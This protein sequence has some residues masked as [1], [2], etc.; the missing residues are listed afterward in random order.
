MH[1]NT[2]KHIW[3]TVVEPPSRM[4]RRQHANLHPVFIP[5]YALRIYQKTTVRI[6]TNEIS[7]AYLS[8][9]ATCD[10]AV[11][12]CKRGAWYADLTQDLTGIAARDQ[13]CDHWQ[14]SSLLRSPTKD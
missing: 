5:S 7:Y 6:S 8:T 12:F 13:H 4:P 11:C 14:L 3:R 1:I 2:H 9:S 10:V